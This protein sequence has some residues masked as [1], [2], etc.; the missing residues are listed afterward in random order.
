MKKALVALV[1]ALSAFAATTAFSQANFTLRADVPFA[2]SI[3]DRQFT[4]GPY[5]LRTINS[6]TVRL[7]NTRTGDACL[8]K[9]MISEKGQSWHRAAPAL[10]FLG[11]GEHAYLQSMTDGDGN[12]WRV[13]VAA[14]YLEVA[15]QSR[16]TNIVVAL[17]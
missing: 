5:E 15:R 13:P 7:L 16:S 1:F 9:L 8:I 3:Q 14:K 11:K 17:K 2:F 4:A 10:Q 12:G 6:S